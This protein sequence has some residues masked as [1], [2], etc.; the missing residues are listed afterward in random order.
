MPV[1]LLQ[2][3]IAAA[4]M[5]PDLYGTSLLALLLD[6]W[7]TEALEWD[8]ETIRR[9]LADE[10][11]VSLPPAAEQKLQAVLTILN[12]D[13]FYRDVMVFQ[14]V[15]RAL[16][17]QESDFQQ[18]EPLEPH[19]AA[20]GVFEASLLQDPESVPQLDEQVCRYVGLILSEHGLHQKPRSLKF[21]LFPKEEA[22]NHADQAS[23]ES[24]PAGADDL[25]GSDPAIFQAFYRR[26]AEDT[27][28]IDDLVR[29]NFQVLLGQL[30]KLP[31]NERDHQGWAGLRNRATQYLQK[32]V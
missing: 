16:C 29:S 22:K 17:G 6:Q 2:E 24:G 4:W 14:H 28:S 10:F 11:G 26:N 5:R 7:G 19:E 31:L 8:P 3:R 21:A 12:S 23:G 1:T 30:D 9:E 20:W 13:G 27:K 15:C 25:V 32:F 18:F